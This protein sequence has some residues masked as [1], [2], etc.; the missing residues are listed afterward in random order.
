M[1]LIDAISG[2]IIYKETGDCYLYSESI[3]RDEEG[4]KQKYPVSENIWGRIGLKT[5]DDVFYFVNDY[6][7][8]DVRRKIYVFD[9]NNNNNKIKNQVEVASDGAKEYWDPVAVSAYVN[10]ITVYDWWKKTFNYCGLNGK[11]SDVNIYIHDPERLNNAAYVYNYI[12]PSTEHLSF[13]DDEY[14][15]LTHAHFLESVAHEYTHAVFLHTVNPSFNYIIGQF[16][17]IN[18]A[19]AD[20]FGCIIGIPSDHDYW[21]VGNRDITNPNNSGNPKCVDGDYYG[22]GADSHVNSTIISHAAFL[23]YNNG[24]KKE[25]LAQ[26]W[27]D[28]L[29][30]GYNMFSEFYD[31]R[32]NVIKSARKNR[33]SA[34]EIKIIKKAFDDVNIREKT[35]NITVQLSVGASYPVA[36]QV[37]LY[38][39]EIDPIICQ[40]QENMEGKIKFDDLEIGSYSIRIDIPNHEPVY[41]QISIGAGKTISKN[42]RI[43]STRNISDV[44]YKVFDHYNYSERYSTTKAKHITIDDDGIKMIG[45]SKAPLKDFIII[46]NDILSSWEYNQTWISFNILRDKNDW[47][48]MEGGGF[49][50]NASLTTDNKLTGYCIL[51][52]TQGLSLYHLSN[53][54]VNLFRDGNLG[55]VMNVG[56]F[57][58]SCPIE[59][60]YDNH[61][62]SLRISKNTISVWD[63]E[64][65]LMDNEHLKYKAEAHDFGP[66]VS[67]ISHACSQISYF[68]FSKIQMSI[69]SGL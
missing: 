10:A 44:N 39:N 61:M 53:V 33:F 28:S 64:L 15:S 38:N 46:K 31:V 9:C 40:L 60:V 18:E 50:F 12:N 59:N 13:G 45:Y 5:E 68:Y 62:I 14:G 49:I 16:K 6:T 11:G 66:M 20:I 56:E 26:L 42:I 69:I 25:R 24:I 1:L 19:Y 54:D 58:K 43:I 2:D 67:H 30:E 57:I 32:S 4:E 35:G 36:G 65:C 52:T 37:V 63:G 34:A 3:G 55:N 7:M 47:H 21:Y 23:M 17:I 51:I 41:T 48:T 27:Y 29:F 8:E 22:I